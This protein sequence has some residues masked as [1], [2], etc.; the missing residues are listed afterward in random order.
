MWRIGPELIVVLVIVLILFG[1]GR[2]TK[3]AGELGSSIRSF[4]DN[5]QKKDEEGTPEDKAE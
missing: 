3:L 1:P 4:R 2:I 5:V